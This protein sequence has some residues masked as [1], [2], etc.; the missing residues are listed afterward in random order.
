M[1]F[2]E[3]WERGNPLISASHPIFYRTFHDHL[4]PVQNLAPA[5]LE[6]VKVREAKNWTLL[7]VAASCG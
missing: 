3:A 5:N 2:I 4:Q 7:H 6:L 1:M